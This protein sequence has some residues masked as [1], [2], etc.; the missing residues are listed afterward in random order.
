MPFLRKGFLLLVSATALLATGCVLLFEDGGFQSLTFH[1][2]VDQE[3]ESGEPFAVETLVH[4]IDI[5]TRRL[6]AQVSGMLMAPGEALPESVELTVVTLAANGRRID[7]IRKS[8]EIREDG[9]F[10]ESQK[11]RKDIP[12]GSMQSITIEPDGAAIPR[13]T[14]VWLCLDIVETRRDLASLTDCSIGGNPGAEPGPDTAIV[15]IQDFQFNP[16]RRRINVGQTV[17]WVLAGSDRTHSVTA[18]DPLDFDSGFDFSSPGDFFEVTFGP[19]T[20]GRTYLYYCQSHRPCCQMQGSI[21]VG[22]NA[23]D[24]PDGY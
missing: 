12:A 14:K 22:D 11:L 21:L 2:T 8:L 15:E 3:I 23:A 1:F 17:R 4:P 13:G 7:R 16:R 19:Q 6:F 5:G 18:E 10:K 9:G 20:D 24:P